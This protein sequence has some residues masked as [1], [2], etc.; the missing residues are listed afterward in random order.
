MEKSFKGNERLGEERLNNQG[1]L[2][3]IIE[4]NGYH[5]I[6]IE[7][8]D[9]HKKKVHTQYGNFLKGNVKNPY[10]ASVHNAGIIGEKY[11]I[12]VNQKQTKEYATWNGILE[13]CFDEKY[14]TKEPAYE[15]VTCCEEWLLF[16]NFYEWLHSQENFEKWYKGKRWNVDK[17][18]LVK[19][20]KVYSPETCCLVPTN[21]NNLFIKRDNFRGC[22]PI[23]VTQIDDGYVAQCNNPFKNNRREYLGYFATPEKAFQAYKNY[24]EDIIKRVAQIEYGKGNITKRCYDAMMSYKVEITD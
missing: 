15:N 3:R 7:F 8:Q 4:Y 13:R 5:D 2:M 10:S 14:K 6:I 18:I 1:T 19:G 21:V 23:G 17:D 9:E 11:L 24:K 12:S 22:L 16:E 20:N